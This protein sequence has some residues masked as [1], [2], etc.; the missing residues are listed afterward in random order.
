MRL[1]LECATNSDCSEQEGFN[2]MENINK[3]NFL[4]QVSLYFSE[5]GLS[6]TFGLIFGLFLW[7]NKN[8]EMKDII[9]EVKISKSTASVELRKLIQF[10][11]IE[12]FY[13]IGQNAQLYRIKNNMWSEVLAQKKNEIDKLRS[14][15]NGVEKKKINKTTSLQDIQ[16]Y[17]DF[18]EEELP[19]LSQKYKKFIERRN[20]K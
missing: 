2:F 10:G 12:K 3:K 19:L 11:A 7:E 6:K 20:K 17:C 5:I 1:F 16:N 4:G 8:F 15:L 9:N 18:M 14:I 13:E